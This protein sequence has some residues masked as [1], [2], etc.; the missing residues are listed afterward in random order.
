MPEASL[1][2]IPTHIITKFQVAFTS[3]AHQEVSGF[4]FSRTLVGVTLPIRL[5]DLRLRGQ[6]RSIWKKLFID[7]VIV[8]H[9]GAGAPAADHHPDAVN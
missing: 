4:F 6:R 9:Y 8:P 2:K 1:M 7:G 3:P 5:E